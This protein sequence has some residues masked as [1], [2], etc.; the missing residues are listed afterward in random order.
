MSWGRERESDCVRHIL[1]SGYPDGLVSIVG[2][3]FDIWSFL[4]DIVGS[5]DVARR[6]RARSGTVVVR[7]D[8]GDPVDMVLKVA[9][10]EKKKKNE[11]SH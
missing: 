5:E 8:S 1:D 10:S 2:D 9:S 11:Q 7:P 4:D 3:S 6:I